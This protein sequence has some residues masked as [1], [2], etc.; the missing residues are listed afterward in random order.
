MIDPKTEY[1]Y[2]IIL[3]FILGVIVILFINQ[4]FDTTPIIKVSKNEQD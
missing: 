4:L 2:N 3:S 1:I